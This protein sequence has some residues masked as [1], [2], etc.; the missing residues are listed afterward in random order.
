MWDWGGERVFK[1][2]VQKQKRVIIA[3]LKLLTLFT[4]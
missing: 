2:I 1:A 4:N 3:R